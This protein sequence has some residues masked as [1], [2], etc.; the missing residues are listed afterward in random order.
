MDSMDNR[1]I[2]IVTEYIKEHLDKSYKL[3]DDF[4][5]YFVW[6][7]KIIQNW[8]YF[9]SSTLSDSMCYELTYDVD[10]KLWYLYA[11][12]EIE[13]R[14]IAEWDY[15]LLEKLGNEQD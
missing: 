3:D 7:T 15:R 13:N 9:I 5:V 14:C 4:E 1:A 2:S 10:M 12:K 6:K 8:K 11:Y